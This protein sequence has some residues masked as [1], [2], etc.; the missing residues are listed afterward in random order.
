MLLLGDRRYASVSLGLAPPV[1][2]S[3]VNADRE[4]E[5]LRHR[6]QT[7]QPFPAARSRGMFTN[8]ARDVA[9]IVASMIEADSLEDRG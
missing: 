1:P 4:R 9:A 7:R 8:Y 2:L 5:A 3:A 6:V